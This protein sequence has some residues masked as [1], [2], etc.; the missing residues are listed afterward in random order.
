MLHADVDIGRL[1]QIVTY[2]QLLEPEYPMLMLLRCVMDISV[3]HANTN[4]NPSH[5]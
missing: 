1:V 4:P 2:D 3:V 5:T